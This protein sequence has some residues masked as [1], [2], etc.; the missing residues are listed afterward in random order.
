[1]FKGA[2]YPYRD[3]VKE[4]QIYIPTSKKTHKHLLQIALYQLT[5]CKDIL[6]AYTKIEMEPTKSLYGY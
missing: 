3:H 5:E 6:A 2:K 1:V 4:F